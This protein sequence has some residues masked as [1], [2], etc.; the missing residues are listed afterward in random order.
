[1]KISS[2]QVQSFIVNQDDSVEK[3]L[4]VMT[5]VVTPRLG[6]GYAIVTDELGQA[7]GVVTDADLRKFSLRA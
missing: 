1:M 2:E 4:D 6:S 3:L 7:I 5:R